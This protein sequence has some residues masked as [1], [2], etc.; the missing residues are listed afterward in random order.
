MR[1]APPA[2]VSELRYIRHLRGP[3]ALRSEAG[4]HLTNFE[5]AVQVLQGFGPDSL[6]YCP[7]ELR[8]TWPSS[9]AEVTEGKLVKEGSLGTGGPRADVARLW[10]ERVLSCLVPAPL[11]AMGQA[12]EEAFEV[13]CAAKEAII[14][15]RTAD[16]LTLSEAAVLLTEYRNLLQTARQ[17][18]AAASLLQE[19]PPHP[20]ASAS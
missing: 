15:D 9:F 5:S 11:I 7:D 12:A 19:S 6:A 13:W 10:P 2:L 8:A 3:D 1:I 4:Y 17:L 18:H 14:K 16:T 20:D